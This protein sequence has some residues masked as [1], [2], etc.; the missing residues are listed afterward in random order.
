MAR[1]SILAPLVLLSFLFGPLAAALTVQGTIL[2]LARNNG[3]AYAATSGLDAH[4]I[5]Y[6]VIV[7]PQ[8]GVTL[9]TLSACATAGDYGGII[10]V[11]ELA[12]EYDGG[13]WGSAIT[14]AQWEAMYA[15]QEAFGVRMVR[16]DAYPQPKFGKGTPKCKSPD[17]HTNING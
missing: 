5:P 13:V 2:V 3:E 6:S 11:S 9:P 8:S 10:T 7:V 17:L 15:Y 4:G 14:D 16:L 12:Y 1:S